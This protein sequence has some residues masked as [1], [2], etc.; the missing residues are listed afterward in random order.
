VTARDDPSR[1]PAA[2]GLAVVLLAGLAVLLAYHPAALGVDALNLSI[3]DVEAL[4]DSWG[5][6][7]VAGSLMLMVLH[8]FVP[9]P[10]EVIAVANGMCFGLVGGIIVTW[11]GAM[12]GALSA[13]AIARG[14]GR[15]LV[16][17]AVAEQR[18]A[19]I[20]R[21]AGNAGT[22]LILRLIPVVSFNLV[23]Y[24]AGLAGT[25]W[26]TFLW[27]TALGILPM[28]ILTA[29]LGSRIFDISWPSWIA[30]GAA[31]IALWLGGRYLWERSARYD[32]R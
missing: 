29:A 17:R 3:E 4:V 13:F 31:V 9:V 16:R 7:G 23:N 26:W 28:T 22:L 15:P 8:S 30:I 14:L 21:Y 11:S 2:I 18:R 20:E 5:M 27:T 6:W 12:L 10:A 24:A 19:R 32:A 1:L 25:G